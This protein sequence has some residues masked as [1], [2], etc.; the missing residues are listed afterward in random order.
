MPIAYYVNR[1][2]VN[3]DI[4]LKVSEQSDRITYILLFEL[5]FLPFL[6]LTFG[7]V[8][9]S[10]AKALTPSPISANQQQSAVLGESTILSSTPTPQPTVIPTPQPTSQPQ[11]SPTPEVPKI[12]PKKNDYKIAVFGDSMVDTMGERLEYLEHAL[13]R[14]YPGVNFTLYNYGKGSENVE[15]GL[16]RL[17]SELHYQDRNYPALTQV[18]PDVLIIGS[19]AYNPFSPHIRDRHWIGLTKLIEQAKNISPAVYMLAEIAPLRDDFG[20]GPNGVNWDTNTAYEHSGHI[21]EQLENAANLAKNL[22]VPIIDVF[23]SS[24]GNKTY[25]NPSDGIHPS[26]AGHEFTAEKI[27]GSLA[28]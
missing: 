8:Y 23:H 16:D 9:F 24:G 19:F 27:A 2:F 12:I 1:K 6:F 14:K 18:K 10:T 17:N 26:A 11:P 20:R 13:K 7:K 25:V 15:M 28:L 3:Y 4:D 5:I 22:N 21:I